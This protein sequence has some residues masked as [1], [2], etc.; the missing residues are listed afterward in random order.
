MYLLLF[1]DLQLL[2]FV[3]SQP[4]NGLELTHNLVPYLL[5]LTLQPQEGQ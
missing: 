3:H 1:V 5:I 4:G 2:S